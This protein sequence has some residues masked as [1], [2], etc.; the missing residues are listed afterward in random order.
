VTSHRAEAPD[1]IVSPRPS[2]LRVLVV[3]GNLAFP[4]AG[5]AAIAGWLPIWVAVIAVAVSMGRDWAWR[6]GRN[7]FRRS[8]R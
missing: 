8:L 2:A 1:R 5:L 7:V 4:V 6:H 3:S